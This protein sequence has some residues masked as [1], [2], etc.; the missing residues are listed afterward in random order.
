MGD[1]TPTP[2][3]SA[4]D[5]GTDGRLTPDPPDKG[6]PGAFDRF[7]PLIR[8]TFDN[9]TANRFGPPIAMGNAPWLA[10]P[11]RQEIE[12]DLAR[13]DADYRTM[14]ADAGMT[15]QEFGVLVR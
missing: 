1:R 6:L 7:A 8:L 10:L 2:R 11:A 3:S 12:A 15:E 9:G 4:S 14:L 13:L 5:R